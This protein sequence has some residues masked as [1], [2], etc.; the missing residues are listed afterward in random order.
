MESLGHMDSRIS[1]PSSPG[2]SVELVRFKEQLHQRMASLVGDLIKYD[3]DLGFAKNELESLYIK[4][5][6]R[7]NDGNIGNTAKALSIHRNTLSK[8]MRDLKITVR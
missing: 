2:G 3:I 7:E 5:V 4:E 6:L 8:R 1:P